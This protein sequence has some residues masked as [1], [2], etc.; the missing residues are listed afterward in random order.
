VSG[1]VITADNYASCSFVAQLVGRHGGI[2]DFQMYA[3]LLRSKTT[4][5]LHIYIWRGISN[6]SL[7]WND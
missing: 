2:L 7:L 5:D 6:R 3:R 4:S 1:R